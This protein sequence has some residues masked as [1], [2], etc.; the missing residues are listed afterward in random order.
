ME[1][2]P[3]AGESEKHVI[4]EQDESKSYQK[5]T[6]IALLFTAHPQMNELPGS[7]I[8]HPAEVPPLGQTD[9]KSV[10]NKKMGYKCLI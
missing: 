7:I 8:K 4:T 6:L 3:A 1:I 9:W 2:R 10:R 5:I